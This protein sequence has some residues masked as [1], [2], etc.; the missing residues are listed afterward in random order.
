MKDQTK[1]D[2]VEK[3][4]DTLRG[5]VGQ[6][7]GVLSMSLVADLQLIESRLRALPSSATAQEAVA[8]DDF[9]NLHKKSVDDSVDL[10]KRRA[11]DFY[12][13][14][15][16][17]RKEFEDLREASQARICGLEAALR[18]A[19]EGL[20]EFHQTGDVPDALEHIERVLASPPPQPASEMAAQEAAVEGACTTPCQNA[21]CAGYGCARIR[22]KTTLPETAAQGSVEFGEALDELIRANTAADAD[23]RFGVERERRARANVERLYSLATAPTAPLSPEAAATELTREAERLGMYDAP[24]MTGGW[25]AR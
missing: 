14:N 21:E 10:H 6:R 17:L 2:S 4:A 25:G 24:P 15:L 23:D 19:H 22:G 13:E 1:T 12:G 20:S 7:A 16:R 18:M 3:I 5:I 9:S 11:W 8:V